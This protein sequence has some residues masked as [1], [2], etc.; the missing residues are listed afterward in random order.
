MSHKRRKGKGSTTEILKSYGI[1]YRIISDA[2]WIVGEEDEI[3][4]NPITKR[5]YT[6]TGVTGTG[7]YSL[8]G[9]TVMPEGDND[10]N[11]TKTKGAVSPVE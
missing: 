3:A 6:K 5:Y 1:P 10:G 4:F 7:V 8:I 11:N 9:K 2:L